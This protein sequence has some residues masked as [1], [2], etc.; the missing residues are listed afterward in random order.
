MTNSI[1]CNQNSDPL[2]LIRDG[3]SQEQRFSPCLDPAYVPVSEHGTAHGMLFGKAV[4]EFVKYFDLSN[5]ESGTL[6]V[7][8]SKDPSLRLALASVQNIEDYKSQI[9]SYFDFLNNLDNELK[10][11]DL[12][13]N[14]SY[15]FSCLVTLGKQLDI[16]KEGLPDEVPLKSTLKNLIQYQLAPSMQR[17]IAYQ[18][19]GIAL[20]VIAEVA[21]VLSIKILGVLPDKYDTVIASGFSKDWIT[22]VATDWNSYIALVPADDSVYGNPLGSIFDRTNHIATHN[23]FTSVSDQFLKVF[24]RVTSEA[25]LAL[26]LTFTNWDRHDPHYALFL[27]YL[28]LMEYSRADV[29]TITGRHLDFYYREILQLKEK[30]AL[31]S[32]A[33][34]FVELAKQAVSYQIKKGEL[35]KAG[36]DDKGIEAFFANEGDLVANQ[37]KVTSL[38]TLYRHGN[39]EVGTDIN[40]KKQAGR[41]FF[42]PIANSNDGMGAEL[43]SPD[44]AWHPFFNKIY[45]NGKLSSIQM[46]LAEVGFA[47]ASHYLWLSEGKRDISIDFEI[48]G[49]KGT[50]GNERASDFIC[51][52]TG[53]KGWIEK[54]PTSVKV[55]AGN[56]LHLLVSLAGDDAAL[57]SYNAKIHGYSFD[58]F[59]PVM[60]FMFRNEIDK[61]F[62]FSDFESTAIKQMQ[63]T[64]AV[65]SVK[66]LLLSNDFGPIDASKPFLP[67]GAIPETGSSMIV[68]SNEIFIKKNLTS[69]N[70]TLRWKNIPDI[71]SVTY[72]QNEQYLPSS[73]YDYYTKWVP[74]INV[75]FLKEGVWRDNSNQT[76][77]DGD[78]DVIINIKPP[79]GEF[80][81]DDRAGFQL[82]NQFTVKSKTGFLKLAL[83]YGLGHKTFRD[84]LSDY[85]LSVSKGSSTVKKPIEPYTPVIESIIADYTATQTIKFDSA[86][87]S[88][89]DKRQAKL[90]NL[91]SFGF[92]EQH[93]FLK[94]SA[95]DNTIFLFP[96]LRHLNI[97]DSSLPEGQ[98]VSHE[99][100]FFI[101]V[102]GL[103]PPQNLSLLIRVED[104]TANPL[105]VKPPLHINWSYLRNNEWIEFNQN[106]VE[107]QTQG[108]LKSGIVT[109]SIPRDASQTNTLL[110]QGQHWIRLAV[111][112]KSDAVCKLILVAAQG[113]T[114]VFT[115]KGNDPNFSSKVLP[116]GTI[117]KLSVPVSDI[118]KIT[119]PFESFGGRGAEK[120]SDF[121]TRVSER[122]RHKDRAVA[123][124]DYERMVLEAF[125][126]IYRVKCLN[127]TQY[128][129]NE[130]G[131]G[132]YRE[133]APGHVTIV[134]IP[135]KQFHNL[136]DPLRPF[137]SLALLQD[138]AAF[139]AVRS[140][141][142]VKLHVNNPQFEEVSVR[143]K[144]RFLDGYDETY[145]TNILQE[146]IVRF[147]SPWAFPDGGNPTFGGKIYKS[148]L[149]DFVDEQPYVDY[150]TD[151]QLFQ[152]IRGIKGTVD[153]NEIE[154]SLAV[155]ILVSVPANQHLIDVINPSDEISSEKCNC[156]S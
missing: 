14:L 126:A 20:S 53:D 153:K 141:C 94:I 149:I 25:R 123:L 47:I 57:A 5:T 137:T 27:S 151:V 22:G 154:G 11:N 140:S 28:R 58:V 4:S 98:I 51:M 69:C 30:P 52:F 3:A 59:T 15:I 117:S 93:P 1:N 19:A 129:P 87:K 92:A 71:K 54:P 145:Y 46:P 41:L 100:E 118:K 32:S 62:A 155:S 7:F 128:E 109:L 74:W 18:N 70:L 120:S 13:N 45:T 68:G 64:V 10:G 33:H 55:T 16:L 80:N 134:T 108:L 115:D 66:N 99:A 37:S 36:K 39:E 97:S 78:N 139:I 95:P 35:F 91:S 147:L 90:F 29:N 132:V 124:W 44:L 49:F 6:G 21:P 156:Q 101:G 138:I 56:N 76:L 102:A 12:I 86:D 8:F 125:P 130:S 121:Y 143:M 116:S 122:L 81:K 75:T 110:P 113:L 83:P 23:L 43:T 112:T 40:A 2:K 96:Q 77:F 89:F 150:I 73:T 142:F 79:N 106:D 9:K 67:F 104:G 135:N 24:S 84:A 105:S 63:L 119:Q 85:M 136:R 103:I 82:D 107:D 60:L 127:H 144:V 111:S 152:N 26:E 146:S 88:V 42:S 131:T 50:I 133:L 17:L 65:D 61:V 148:V 48:S 72:L 31:P 38:K 34:L 114:A